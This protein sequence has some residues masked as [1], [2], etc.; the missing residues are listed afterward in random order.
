MNHS[1]SA[2]E[3][4]GSLKTKLFM[5]SL[6]TIHKNEFDI[7]LKCLIKAY[8][9]T[10]NHICAYIYMHIYDYMISNGK[11]CIKRIEEKRKN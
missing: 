8:N 5:S 2:D 4:L 6:N 1:L 9:H 3:K 11:T 10:Y 7:K